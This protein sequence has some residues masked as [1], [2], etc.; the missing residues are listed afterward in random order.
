MA[1][2]V[3]CK[4]LLREFANGARGRWAILFWI[5]TII[6]LVHVSSGGIDASVS[7]AMIGFWFFLVLAGA[8]T[9]MGFWQIRQL[10]CS[11]YDT[12][13]HEPERQ[14]KRRMFPDH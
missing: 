13:L 2:F 6:C 12:P 5:M 7:L 8:L 14:K 3:W 11:P 9:F 1:K 10:R 4:Q